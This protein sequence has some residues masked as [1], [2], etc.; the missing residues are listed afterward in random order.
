MKLCDCAI[1][2]QGQAEVVRV[3]D[4]AGS[5]GRFIADGRE[6]MVGSEGLKISVH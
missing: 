2:A 3:D 5:H 4:E 6:N 1:D